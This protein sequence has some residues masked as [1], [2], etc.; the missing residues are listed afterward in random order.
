[1]KLNPYIGIL[2][3]VFFLVLRAERETRK[4]ARYKYAE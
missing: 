3:L 2:L 1:M 4:A